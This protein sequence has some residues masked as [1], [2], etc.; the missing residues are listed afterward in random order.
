MDR[1]GDFRDSAFL[2]RLEGLHLAAKRLA[3]SSAAGLCRSRAVGDGLEFADHRAYAPGDDIR[4]LDWRYAARMEKWLLRR[5]HRHS[6][7]DV[8]VLL[9]TSASMSAGGAEKFRHAQRLAAALAYVAVGGGRRAVVQTFADELGPSYRSARDRSKFLP[10][11]EF[12]ASLQTGGRTA[13]AACARRFD[14][15]AV[16]VG[17]VILISDLWECAADLPEALLRLGREGRDVVVLHAYGRRDAEPS[18]VGALVLRDAESGREM[19]VADGESLRQ[20]YLWAWRDHCNALESACRRR[21]TTYLPVA[22]DAPFERAVL[23]ALLRA[24]VL[25]RA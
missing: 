13:M 19:N 11:L 9:D 14:R 2:R 20:S 4:F 21:E 16:D 22:D 18:L 7:S 24:G 8:A 5:F 1:T 10:L 15:T 23:Q 6:E 17:T 25:E 12:L 3:V